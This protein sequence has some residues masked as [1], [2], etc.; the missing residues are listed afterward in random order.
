MDGDSVT[1]GGVDG[2]GCGVKGGRRGERGR[3]EREEG[4]QRERMVET[5]EGG[6]E[7]VEWRRE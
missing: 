3:E 2:S 4:K 5:R 1:T 6:R 7:E